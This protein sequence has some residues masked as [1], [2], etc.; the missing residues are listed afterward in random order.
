MY[1]LLAQTQ[2]WAKAQLINTLLF[3]GSRSSFLIT[4]FLSSLIKIMNSP[5]SVSGLLQK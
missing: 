5:D 1:I 2:L 4:A 3:F